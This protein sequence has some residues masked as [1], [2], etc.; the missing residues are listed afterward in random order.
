[1]RPGRT[2]RE[3]RKTRA[4]ERAE[5]VQ[6]SHNS[7]PPEQKLAYF[8]SKFGKG[9]GATKERLRCQLQIE[10]AKNESTTE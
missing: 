8:D 10:R 1:M 6:V 9:L 4:Q 2:A 3:E 7:L 5:L